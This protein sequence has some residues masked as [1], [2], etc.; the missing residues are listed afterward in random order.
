MK[1]I[2]QDARALIGR[3]TGGDLAVRPLQG[4]TIKEYRMTETILRYFMRKAIGASHIIKPEVFIT[5]PAMFPCGAQVLREDVLAQVQGR[6]RFTLFQNHL[7]LLG[8]GFACV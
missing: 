1:A 8:Y 4:G 5:I 6:M 3:T 7:P 2:G